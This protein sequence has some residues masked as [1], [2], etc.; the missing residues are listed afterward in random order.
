M[1]WRKIRRSNVVKIDQSGKEQLVNMSK[2]VNYSHK[3]STTSVNSTVKASSTSRADCLFVDLFVCLFVIDHWHLNTEHWSACNQVQKWCSRKISGKS[4]TS[5]SSANRSS[6][7]GKAV[8]DESGI[9]MGVEV[10][11]KY[12]EQIQIRIQM[13]STSRELDSFCYWHLLI[14][15]HRMWSR[16]LWPRNHH[17]TRT[18][19]ENKLRMCIFKT[20]A[21]LWK[22]LIRGSSSMSL[23]WFSSIFIQSKKDWF[24][25]RNVKQEQEQPAQDALTARWKRKGFKTF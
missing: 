12:N 7:N 17:R 8:L 2:V 19:N 5:S 6:A 21:R 25:E 10:E 22:A 13:S 3:F 11:Y 1:G 9:G 24:P 20:I 15:L 14:I 16:R 18:R 4:E 23:G